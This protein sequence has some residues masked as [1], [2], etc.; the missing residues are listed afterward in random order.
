MYSSKGQI[1]RNDKG[2]AQPRTPGR[3]VRSIDGVAG[4]QI[5][6]VTILQRAQLDPGSLTAGDM[7]R[8]QRTIGN[9][10]VGQLMKSMNPVQAQPEKEEDEEPVQ[11]KPNNT[12]MPDHLKAGVESLS[13]ISMD[14]VRVHYNSDKPMGFGALAYT[15][16]TDIHV[17]PGQE[18]HL[19]HE[20]WHVAQQKE[21]RVEPTGA[22]GGMPLNDSRP[23]ETEADAMGAKAL[24]F[25]KT[26]ESGDPS[27]LPP[28][29]ESKLSNPPIIPDVVQ[30]FR[31]SA[32]IMNRV[33][34]M[35]GNRK[36]YPK[37]HYLN[38][39]NDSHITIEP[40]DLIS[41]RNRVTRNTTYYRFYDFHYTENSPRHG[42][43]H[44]GFQQI[45]P[46]GSVRITWTSRDFNNAPQT[47]QEDVE[48]DAWAGANDF[49][50]DINY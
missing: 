2:N 9:R 45:D 50:D 10:A 48:D 30:L 41:E 34:N 47:I 38:R 40:D 1:H 18:R 17:A 37:N 32:G 19:A 42:C 24:Q 3:S 12:G 44:I 29:K 14:D 27:Q 5:H 7:L 21:G 28:E 16:G 46:R 8:L 15:Q 31:V 43:L 13:G 23:L 25:K 36:I 20:A 49:R 26:K 22:I 6:P 35:R 11:M 39:F 4:P 33:C